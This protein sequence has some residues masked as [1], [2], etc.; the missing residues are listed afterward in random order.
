MCKVLKV[1][2]S[3]YYKSLELKP[4]QTEIKR[5]K[6]ALLTM[7]FHERS[8]G[9]YGYRKVLEYIRIE[10]PELAC[11]PETLRLIMASETLYSCAK[12]KHRY[13]IMDTCKR[14]EYAENELNKNFKASELN[15]KLVADITYIITVSGWLYL[16]TVMDLFSRRIVDWSMSESINAELACNA[17]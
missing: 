4:F 9:V 11:A 17:L 5:K 16:A 3:G 10:A 15:M 13:P 14:Y 8:N 6:I 7:K 2:R 1:S 12:R